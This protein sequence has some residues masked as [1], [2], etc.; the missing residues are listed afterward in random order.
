MNNGEKNIIDKFLDSYAKHGEKKTKTV[1]VVVKPSKLKCIGGFIFSLIIFIILL[2]FF[3]FNLTYFAMLIGDL[4]IML[5]YGINLFTEKGFGLP[6]S[7]EVPL[8]ELEDDED[9]NDYS[10][11]YK[12]Q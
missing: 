9:L 5:Y 1:R 6:R 7:V 2:T 11:R 3:T 10:D 8:D 4:L 12:V